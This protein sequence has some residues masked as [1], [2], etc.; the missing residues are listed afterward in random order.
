MGGGS[1]GGLLPKMENF[2]DLRNLVGSSG[3]EKEGVLLPNLAVTGFDKG[4]KFPLPKR[5][6]SWDFERRAP[7]GGANKSLRACESSISARKA[8]GAG[9][10]S[11][12]T[13]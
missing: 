10:I 11:S 2:L 8:K 5:D 4:L 13:P 7:D 12:R 3:D 6:V 9:K 1:G